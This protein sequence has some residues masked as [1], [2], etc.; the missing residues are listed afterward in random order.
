MPPFW[1]PFWL[2][3]SIPF[4]FII[5]L[6]L[7]YLQLYLQDKRCQRQIK[8]G[9]D[10]LKEI[11][12]SMSETERGE[13]PVIKKQ[14][15]KKSKSKIKKLAKPEPLYPLAEMELLELSDSEEADSSEEERVAL[16]RKVGGVVPTAPPAYNPQISQC[17]YSFCTNQTRQKI[18][19]MFPVFVN[20]DDE[21]YHR[22]LEH[23]QVK[24]LAESVRTYG[25]NASYTQSQ[26]ERLTTSALTPADWTFVTKA[27]LSTG[28]YLDWKSI[29]YDLCSTQAR[30]NAAAGQPAW[31][32]DMLT[33]Q[34]QWIQNQT[35]YPEQVYQQINTAAFKA[36]K[37]LPN[38][39]EVSG[40]L[41]KI[42]QG[43][44]EP[45][46]DFVARMMDSA[47]KIFGDPESA[48]PLI[49]Q[50]V[51]E[52][53]T[54]ECRIAI[55]PWKGKGLQAWLKACREIGGALPRAVDGL[56][57]AV[58]AVQSNK[59]K[60][61]CYKCG[62][63]GHIQRQCRIN[64]KTQHNRK[65][66]GIC[67]KCKKGKHWANECKSVKDING[68][69][70]DQSS[71]Q[72]FKDSKNGQR[73]PRPQGPQM[74]GALQTPLPSFRPPKPHEEPLQVRGDWTSVPPLEQY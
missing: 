20:D 52:Q 36:W 40:N 70:L 30:A 39:G 21:R 63:E 59:Q 37:K 11:Q 29:W 2:A 66:P 9:Q 17:G 18:R 58:L 35:A 8:Q 68:R 27:T 33:G 47:G 3:V 46:S 71:V 7:C 45:F 1:D 26:V 10:L 12:E 14:I 28:Q 22:P 50:L 15:E 25:V 64:E 19:Q 69:P 32:F 13:G 42:I 43:P 73:G 55:T 6:L 61:S 51:Y 54:R 65:M 56:A 34:G 62:K 38:R 72:Q 60:I 48:M 24:E 5:I 53:C 16:R 31:N 49:E 67:P 44:D 74:Y 23:K 57:A 4:M 41:T